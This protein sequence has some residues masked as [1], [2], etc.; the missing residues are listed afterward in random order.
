[1][2]SGGRTRTATRT[3]TPAAAASAAISV[4]D[5]LDCDCVAA[6]SAPGTLCALRPRR[7]SSAD[8]RLASARLLPHAV[9]ATA[10]PLCGSCVGIPCGFSFAM[11]AP[12]P[13]LP[14]RTPPP[15]PTQ[16]ARTV[17]VPGRSACSPLRGRRRRRPLRRGETP[18][19]AV[20]RPI[21]KRAVEYA[22][23]RSPQERNCSWGC[24]THSPPP[25]HTHLL[26]LDRG[27]SSAT[28]ISA[29]HGHAGR[30]TH[31]PCGPACVVARHALRA[32]APGRAPRRARARRF[33]LGP[34]SGDDG[35]VV[36]AVVECSRPR[37]VPLQIQITA[38]A[39][40][41]G[42]SEARPAASACTIKMVMYQQPT[43]DARCGRHQSA[44]APNSERSLPGQRE[45]APDTWPG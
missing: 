9:R 19:G 33:V 15:Q 4:D 13:A 18:C 11:K 23:S 7:P 41:R 10:V 36:H 45:T 6:Q 35:D 26:P 42:G 21:F 44:R 28:E 25:T 32:R 17:P 38:P 31:A 43:K 34:P 20:P 24:P 14:P 5:A 22:I 29:P 27:P 1:M 40:A 12:S 2:P 37:P 30:A 3:A 8:E 16:R 39:R